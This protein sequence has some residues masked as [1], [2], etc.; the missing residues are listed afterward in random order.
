MGKSSYFDLSMGQLYLS[1]FLFGCFQTVST[2]LW[3]EDVS[4]LGASYITQKPEHL[5]LTLDCCPFGPSIS[6]VSFSM[7]AGSKSS[8]TLRTPP[9]TPKRIRR[10]A[11]AFFSPEKSVDASDEC[12]SLAARMK[13]LKLSP[14]TPSTKVKTSCL[15]SSPAF[16]DATTLVLGGS[17]LKTKKH[18]LKSSPKGSS[19]SKGSP[20]SPK[21]KKITAPMKT[22]K[23]LP[24]MKSFKVQTKTVSAMKA[25]VSMKKPS[26]QAKIV[27]KGSGGGKKP[28]KKEPLFTA[29]LGDE[30]FVVLWKKWF[31]GFKAQRGHM[32]RMKTELGRAACEYRDLVNHNRSFGV[33][34][35]TWKSFF[36]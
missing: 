8:P 33:G 19:S 15:S 18:V 27:T 20:L 10:S 5:A 23:V 6:L 30:E 13:N 35:E 21:T 12:A 17:P 28:T 32:T 26:A 1:S 2:C 11:A 25:K 7:V 29:Q 34:A 16:S 31:I 4:V 9:S 22:E 14:K 36:G 24:M 3:E